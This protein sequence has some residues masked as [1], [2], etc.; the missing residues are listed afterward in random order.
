MEENRQLRETV[1]QLNSKIETLQKDIAKLKKHSR[2]SSKPPSS[3]IVKPQKSKSSQQTAKPKIGG[4]IGHPKQSE[5]LTL[6]ARF[7][8]KEAENYFRF[9]ATSG[10]EPTNNLTEQA[11]RHIVIDRHITQGTRGRRGQRWSERV[12]TMIATCQQQKRNVFDFF[13][14]AINAHFGQQVAPSPLP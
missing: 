13:C 3:D 12:W 7:R 4:Q 8:G 5:A 2:N 14:S 1:Q 10:I 11:I 9:L 6:A